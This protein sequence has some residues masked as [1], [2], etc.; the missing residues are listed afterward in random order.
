MRGAAN[1]LERE[2]VPAARIRGVF[3]RCTDCT[4]NLR[5]KERE[6][7]GG[8]EGG[9]ERQRDRERKTEREVDWVVKRE[10]DGLCMN[11]V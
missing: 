9:R 3:E 4:E 10:M 5:L 11:S 1:R 8:R 7:E 2:T 6:R